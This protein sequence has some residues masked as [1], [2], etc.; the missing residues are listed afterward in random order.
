MSVADSTNKSHQGNK[1]RALQNAIRSADFRKMRTRPPLTPAE[2]DK[3]IAADK[4]QRASKQR[5]KG[6]TCSEHSRQRKKR[7]MVASILHQ[8][9]K[10]QQAEKE[11]R[12]DQ[13]I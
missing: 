6:T 3:A 2:I 4:E 7:I 13:T 1:K 5:I 11:P 9:R 10:E 8:K 12:S